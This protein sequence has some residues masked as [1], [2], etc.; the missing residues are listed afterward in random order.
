[1]TELNLLAVQNASLLRE[2]GKDGAAQTATEIAR[3]IGRDESNVR[4]SIKAL[5]AAG[6]ATD[7]MCL[8][9]E[10]EKQLEA[11]ERAE[12]GDATGGDL[13]E[14]LIALVHAQIFPDHQNAR[15]DWDSEEAQAELDALRADIV[16]NGLL[17]NLVVRAEPDGGMGAVIRVETDQGERLPL[18]TLIGGERRWRAIGM[19]IADGEWPEDRP[20]LCRLLDADPLETRIAALAENLLRRKLNPIEKATG[21]QQLADLGLEN[22]DIAGRLGFTPE[23]V[24]QH[25]RFLKLDDADRQRM[26]LPKDDPRHLSVREARQKLSAKDAKDAAWKPADHTLA[27]QLLL[28]EMALSVR[29]QSS[30]LGGSIPVGPEARQD[31]VAAALVAKGVIDLSD[32]PSP[33]GSSAGHYSAHFRGWS[34]TD[35]IRSTWPA[36]LGAEPE[37]R[38]EALRQLQAQAGQMPESEAT[39]VTL[40]LN[41][42]FSLTPEG[43]AIIA[44]RAAERE[45][46]A[47][48]AAQRDRTDKA[49]RAR[50]AEARAKH[51]AILNQAAEAPPPNL[52]EATVE[53]AAT[54][55]KP[56]PWTL[57][58]NGD[59]LD[60]NGSNVE[61]VEIYRPN[62]QEMTFLQMLVLSVNS[63][64]GLP[65]PPV[66]SA[67]AHYAEPDEDEFLA[68]MGAEVSAR[69]PELDAE[70]HSALT[71]SIL[72]DFLS[73]NGVAFGEEGF[74]WTDEGAKALVIAH[75]EA[76]AE[77]EAA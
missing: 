72:A 63:A 69:Q 51:L 37:V 47:E 13:P 7:P 60:A 43:E 59:I 9:L 40:W 26:T 61:A 4:K 38:L 46:A 48:A 32:A 27:E 31:P 68:A 16:R 45:A 67:E 49:A 44:T 64:A 14:G 65:T 70:T 76:A 29:A 42:P 24:Q 1:M 77:D 33:Y 12:S 53:A 20:I 28:A 39:F 75:Y 17:Q 15:Q 3:N 52:S 5:V 36:L 73:D 23:H 2:L 58:D 19:A 18:Y 11:I 66:K 62:D 74:D 10:G 35:T 55:E 34:Y 30:Y 41:E 71:A 6:L 57:L 25:R 50:Y 56:L 21:F 22:K 54:L 8:T